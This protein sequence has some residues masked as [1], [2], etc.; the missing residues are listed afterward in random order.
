MEVK[1]TKSKKDPDAVTIDRF[2]YCLQHSQAEAKNEESA[3]AK[4]REMK[5]KM[6]DARKKLANEKKE[7]KS[8]VPVPVIPGKK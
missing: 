6:S 3:A 7:I 5:R 2:A 1:E 4:N 8:S